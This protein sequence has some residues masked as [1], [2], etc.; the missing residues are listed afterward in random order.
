V[1]GAGGEPP[2]EMPQRTAVGR[3]RGRQER[4]TEHV[5]A[6]GRVRVGRRHPRAVGRPTCS[7]RSGSR[8]SWSRPISSAAGASTRSRSGSRSPET[9]AN[10]LLF[11]C[12][13]GTSMLVNG[14][15]SGNSADHTR[16]RFWSTDVD[17]DV[18]DLVA[19]GVG[20]RST[21]SRRSG[22]STTSSPPPPGV[23]RSAWSRTPTATRSR[24]SGRSSR[25]ASMP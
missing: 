1:G 13:D 7:P 21:T 3:R 15:P 17:R 8:P 2:P 5:D 20:S 12:G 23:G 25:P 11:D 6:A 9:I 24:S 19:R 10:R 18:A 16:V 14:R 22:P 4:P